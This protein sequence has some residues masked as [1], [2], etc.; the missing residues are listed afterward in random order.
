MTHHLWRLSACMLAASA[1][2][3]C[4][5]VSEKWSQWRGK[6]ESASTAAPKAEVLRPTAETARW[7]GVYS[8]QAD[9]GRFQEC[10]SGQTVP[11]LME[12]DNALL[13]NA[14]LASR[15]GPDAAMLAAVDGRIVER[16]AADPVDAQ[17]GKKELALRVERFVSLSSVA[18]CA[19]GKATALGA[20]N[21]PPSAAAASVAAAHTAEAQAAPAA[22]TTAANAQAAAT[23][24]PKAS[25][26]H[27]TH[28]ALDNTYW[29]LLTLQGKA[30]PRL[31]KEAHIILQSQGKL[32][33]S[34]GCN[35]LMGSWK[36]D[37]AQLRISQVGSTR[38]ACK[39]AGASTESAMLKMLGRVASWRIHGDQLEL[40]DAKG[41]LL[42]QW[43][44]VALR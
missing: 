5:T 28:P 6:G 15:I 20:G 27:S 33:G 44:A 11:V 17:Q 14:Y 37:G 32:A 42:A 25:A 22:A 10:K 21:A 31:E 13:E 16:V 35:R 34:G 26:D 18:T 40:L 38:M 43:R 8:Y 3:G 41:K 19:V 39:G 24:K 4:S 29:K 36:Q 30:V 2:I 1:L 12:G 9:S 7:Q 23:T